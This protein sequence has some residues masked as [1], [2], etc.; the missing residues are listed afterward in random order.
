MCSFNNI[1]LTFIWKGMIV[2]SKAVNIVII[3]LKFLF[4]VNA[5]INIS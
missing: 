4:N 3:L 2:K 5:I 1:P